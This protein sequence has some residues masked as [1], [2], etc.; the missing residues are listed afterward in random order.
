MFGT[1][2]RAIFGSIYLNTYGFHQVLFGEM[3]A[4]MTLVLGTVETPSNL[5]FMLHTQRN[6]TETSL[7]A[8]SSVATLAMIYRL[9]VASD[10]WTHA[11]QRFRIGSRIPGSQP[12][13][14]ETGKVLLKPSWI[15]AS[16]ARS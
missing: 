2:T 11:R 12:V 13:V 5:G 15:C 9:F 14:G 8:L 6:R 1:S 7:V 4:H 3:R 16:A 10:A